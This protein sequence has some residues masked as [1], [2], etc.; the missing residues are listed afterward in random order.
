MVTYTLLGLNADGT[1]T[2]MGYEE[3]A[4]KEHALQTFGKTKLK[5]GL[6]FCG[7]SDAEYILKWF[8]AGK[9]FREPATRK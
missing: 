1:E 5:A 6:V 2:E 7:I 9:E 4:S 8:E 3:A